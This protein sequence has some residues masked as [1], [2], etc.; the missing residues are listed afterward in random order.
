M[1]SRLL[2][3]VVLAGTTL[4]GQPP[5]AKEPYR[6]GG[7]VIPPKVVYKVE[8]Q[9]TEEG[10][11][12]RREGTV[13]IQLVVTRDGMPTDVHELEQHI[14]LG[15][16]EKAIEAVQQWRF[17][18]GKKSGEPVAVRVQIEMNFHLPK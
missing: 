6:V 4:C 7:S 2:L 5:E 14:G 10:L 3:L 16:D 17:E 9:Y 18:P 13:R 12:A 15:L 8:P 11:R 1:R